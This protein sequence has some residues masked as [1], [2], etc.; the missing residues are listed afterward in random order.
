MELDHNKIS[1]LQKN[2]YPY[3]LVDYVDEIIPGKSA[4]GYKNLTI[5]DWFF[6]CHFPND[7]N[8]PGMLQVEALVQMSALIVL[9][10]DGNQGEVAYLTSGK[11]LKV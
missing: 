11:N 9:I 7:P 8:M 1:E 3:L 2:K 4:K 6:D 10:L 5:N